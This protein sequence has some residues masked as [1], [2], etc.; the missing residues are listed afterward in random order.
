LANEQVQVL[1]AILCFDANLPSLDHCKVNCGDN[2]KVLCI[3][4]FN[5][6]VG[7][8]NF[9]P[10]RFPGWSDLQVFTHFLGQILMNIAKGIVDPKS[11]VFIILTK[12]RNFIDDVREE[13]EARKVG[14]CLSLI[15][16][17]NSIMLGGIIVIIQQI[18]CQAYGTR[19]V[20]D[21]KCAFKKVN[22]FL[23]N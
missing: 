8:E 17:G 13:Y 14:M 18:D 7:V 20:S 16:S 22:D 1:E 19:R 12:D 10:Q 6:R 4:R 2:K 15:F 9:D 21:L 11:C 5:N 3:H 23:E